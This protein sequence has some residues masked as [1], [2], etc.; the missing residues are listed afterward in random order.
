[1]AP[2]VLSIR[3]R[4]IAWFVARGCTNR[5]I[6]NML[7]CTSHAVKKQLSSLFTLLDVSNRTEL[8]AVAARWPDP[9]GR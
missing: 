8:A 1:M 6:A 4:Q 9:D 5:E 3:Q 2:S 7:G